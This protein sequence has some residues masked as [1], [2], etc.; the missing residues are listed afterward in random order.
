MLPSKLRRWRDTFVGRVMDVE[1]I[2]SHGL[3]L[4]DRYSR[5]VTDSRSILGLNAFRRYAAGELDRKDLDKAHKHALD[6]FW[7]SEV[8]YEKYKEDRDA[9]AADLAEEQKGLDE[10]R[11]YSWALCIAY[12]D[13]AVD[14]A[15]M[16]MAEA[17]SFL[18]SWEDTFDKIDEIAEAVSQT[19][20]ELAYADS[21]E[22]TAKTIMAGEQF[23]TRFKVWDAAAEAG[24]ATERAAQ[25]LEWL[26]LM[27]QSEAEVDEEENL[28]NDNPNGAN[29]G[30]TDLPNQSQGMDG[31]FVTRER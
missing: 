11:A 8:R 31:F 17:V 28:S 20:A 10:D 4:V 30:N 29:L 25:K 2:R 18:T 14:R 19:A 5:W 27:Q 13:V 22:A 1:H 12:A 16:C 15:T 24:F 3:W 6:A 7:D 26:R 21:A 9:R 23:R